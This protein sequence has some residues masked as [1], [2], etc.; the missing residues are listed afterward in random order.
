[1]NQPE[2]AVLS[3][4]A[5]LQQCKGQLISKG[6][7]YKEVKEANAVVSI[8]KASGIESKNELTSLPPITRN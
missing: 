4:T 3:T 5:P 2:K 1:M 7:S 8:F 6:Y